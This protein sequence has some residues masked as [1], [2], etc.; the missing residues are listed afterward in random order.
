[1]LIE[2][3]LILCLRV[4][5]LLPILLAYQRVGGSKLS[6]YSKT[7]LLFG[8]MMRGVLSFA[9]MQYLLFHLSHSDSEVNR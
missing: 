6:S 3:G 8:G 1:M 5:V 2:V 9:L 4:G 7:Q